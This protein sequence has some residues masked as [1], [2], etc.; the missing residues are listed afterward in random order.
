VRREETI[1]I[2]E[3]IG[4]HGIKG[5]LKVR[6]FAESPEIF[7]PDSRIWLAAAA[8]DLEAYR[9]LRVQPHKRILLMEFDGVSDRDGAEALLGRTLHV[10]RETLP[11]LDE[12][13][14][15]HF[16]LIGL[17][18]YSDTDEYVG[19]IE[20]VMQTGSNDVLVVKDPAGPPSA[21]RLIPALASVVVAVDLKEKRVRVKLPEGL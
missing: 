5:L 14:Y 16:E 17:D 1:V 21:E 18:V 6:S 13:T 11:T 9:I 3:I 19:R 2:G 15:Y 4:L 7:T 12:D 20:T 8:G 10:A